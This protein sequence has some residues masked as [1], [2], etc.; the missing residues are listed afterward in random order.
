[1][2]THLGLI[3]ALLIGCGAGDDGRPPENAEGPA[4]SSSAAKASPPSP[5]ATHATANA[6]PTPTPTAAF[7]DAQVLGLLVALNDDEIALATAASPNVKDDRVKT[8]AKQMADDHTQAKE[9]EAGL[10]EQMKLRPIDTDKARTMKTAAATE[11]EKLKGLSGHALDVEYV[12]EQVRAHHD[13][14]AM[15]DTQLLPSTSISELR[16]H[17]TDFRA[18][19]EHHGRDAEALQRVIGK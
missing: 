6:T 17:L 18:H 2:R 1:M 7:A 8:F 19:V 14:L 16:A 9:Q 10:A 11:S 5:H 13:A 15:I 12:D 4:A 3:A